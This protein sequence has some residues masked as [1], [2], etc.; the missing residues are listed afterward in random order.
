L[1]DILNRVRYR[2]EVFVVER[3]GKPVARIGPLPGTTGASLRTGLEAWRAAGDPDP[4]FAD[5]LER[6]GAADHIPEDPWRVR[7]G[8]L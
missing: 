5:D 7:K 3:N 4:R 8:S 1:G 2:S 6:V